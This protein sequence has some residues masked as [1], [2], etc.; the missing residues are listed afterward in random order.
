MATFE[1]FTNK[2]LFKGKVLLLFKASEW[3]KSVP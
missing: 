2:G 3:Y 1:V